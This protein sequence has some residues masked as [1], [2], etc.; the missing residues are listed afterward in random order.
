[1]VEDRENC[2]LECDLNMKKSKSKF[3]F[4]EVKELEDVNRTA[5]EFRS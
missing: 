5:E 1:M 2:Y 3:E 4:E